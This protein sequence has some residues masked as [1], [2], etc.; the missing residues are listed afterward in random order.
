[1]SSLPSSQLTEITKTDH[2]NERC[3]VR[4][5]YAHCHTPS[6]LFMHGD[7]YYNNCFVCCVLLTDFATIDPTTISLPTKKD[8]R[9]KVLYDYNYVPIISL[10]IITMF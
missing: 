7:G 6:S 4:C 1:M 3:R 10:L 8:S 2:A 5:T 9:F